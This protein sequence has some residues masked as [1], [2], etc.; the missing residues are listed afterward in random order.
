MGAVSMGIA[1]SIVDP[2]FLES[3]LGMRY[4]MIDMS[5]FT[6]RIDEEIFDP[7]ELTRALAWVKQNCREGKDYNASNIQRSRAQKDADWEFVVKMAMIGRDLMV[8][9]PRLEEM[10]YGEEALGHNAIASGFQG[11]RQWTDHFPNGDFMET[12]LNTSFDWNGI[13]QP[14]VCATEND[15]CNGISML[16][17]HL[18]T[19]TAQIFSDVRTYW[20]PDAV[21]RVTGKKA[22]GEA[23]GGFIHLINSGSTCLDGTGRQSWNGKPAIKPW[24]EVTAEEAGACLEATSFCPANVG[25]FRGGG[26]SSE[27]ETLGGMPVTMCRLNMVAGLGP[28]LQV[29]EGS[30]VGLPAEMAAP[31]EQRTDPSWPT[32]WFVPRTTGRGAFRDVYSVMNNWGA[33]HGAISYGHVGGDLITL[34]SIL[35]IPVAMHNVPPEQIFRPKYWAS[36]GDAE[37][38][39]A[40]Y[41]A[42]SMLGPLYG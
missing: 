38:E 17:G 33:N 8:G 11:Q 15:Y 39:G 29:A 13:R 12:M 41:R 34:A 16:F 36:F 18:L 14:F 27:F 21:K 28:V 1:G 20:S 2:R 42:C 31:L 26:Y 5:E 4:E 6:R 35:R 30:T 7:Q 23:E 9:N 3:W 37:S 19:G 32:T 10:G 22:A 25:Y 40:D 24:W